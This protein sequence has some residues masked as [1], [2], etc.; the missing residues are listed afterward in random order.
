MPTACVL[1]ANT[2]VHLKSRRLEITRANPETGRL[3]R[4]REIPIHDLD[5][6]IIDE[7]VQITSKAV[8]ELMRESIPISMLGWNGRF[9]GGFLPVEPAH[10]GFRLSQYQRCL[11]SD[12]V[13]GMAKSWVDGKIYNQRRVLQRLIAARRQRREENPSESLELED[14]TAS[15]VA[16]EL[17]GYMKALLGDHTI[18]EI[19]GYEG[20]STSRYFRAWSTFLPEGVVF[21]YRSTR[22]P[23][24]PVNACISFASTLLYQEGVAFL[25]AHGLDP[26][27]GNLHTTEDGRW[28]LALDMMEPFRPA[29]GEALTLDMFSRSMLS[30]EEHFEPCKGGI[31]LNEAGRRKFILQYE[32]RMER[33]FMS[34]YAG[35]RT[36]LRQQ[37]EQQAVSYKTSL[38][39]PETFKPFRM[40]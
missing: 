32:R 1:Q 39:Q 21:E 25:H 16:E 34:E 22:P 12:F 33:Q 35:H 7:N 20:A 13:L 31:Y 14:T 4:I 30:V 2:T 40:N 17:G 19:R 26:S 9:L 8:A 37:L 24:N 3:E 28:S 6:L 11:E 23:H 36:T 5:R 27:L 38:K 15:R 29:V 18:D 10:G